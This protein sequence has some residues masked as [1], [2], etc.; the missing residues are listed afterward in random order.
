MFS[1]T[2]SIKRIIAP[3]KNAFDYLEEIRAA[4]TELYQDELII[5][6]LGPTATV[7]ASEFADMNMQALDLGHIDLEYIWYRQK[8]QEIAPVNDRY[9]NECDNNHETAECKD[10]QYKKEI[11][12]TINS[13]KK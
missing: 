13:E 2:N 4:A 12:Y 8:A 5:M 10:E 3:A 1:N 11:I 7:L 9:V 6:A